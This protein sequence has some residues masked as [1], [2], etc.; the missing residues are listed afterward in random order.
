MEA[1]P[2]ESPRRWTQA[3]A[4][5]PVH[6]IVDR[7][8]SPSLVDYIASFVGDIPSLLPRNLLLLSI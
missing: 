1:R 6:F 2:T 5:L 8:I 4:T 3:V 7:A